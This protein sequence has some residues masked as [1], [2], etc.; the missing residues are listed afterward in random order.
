M[1]LL[2]FVIV[3][4][5]CAYAL[6]GERKG[7]VLGAAVGP[8]TIPEFL[9]YSYASYRI[10]Q[11]ATEMSI[12]YAPTDQLQ[13]TYA[14][15]SLWFPIWTF[16]S[17]P[18]IAATYYMKPEA[19]SFLVTGGGGLAVISWGP[20]VAVGN[21]GGSVFGGVGYEFYRGWSVRLEYTHSWWNDFDLNVD[22]VRVCVG[23]LLY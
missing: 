9:E 16:V 21:L 15:R 1:W 14:G 18:A 4:S 12:G 8:A 7:L 17:T 23:M 2:A 10:I 6:D 3:L 5:A 20:F 11:V 22:D 13:F 19:P